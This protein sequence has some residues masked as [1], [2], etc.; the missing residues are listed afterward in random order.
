M[1]FKLTIAITD[2]VQNILP[3]NYQYELSGWI[4]KVIHQGD[5]MFSE[6]LHN[7]G[8]MNEKKQL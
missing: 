4:Y 6:W 7:N 5:A 8:Y 3:I 2:K 1:R